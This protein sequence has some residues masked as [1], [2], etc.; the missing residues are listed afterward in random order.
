MWTKIAKKSDFKEGVGQLFEISGKQIAVFKK[1]GE[2][3]ALHNLCEHRGGPLVE[4][5]IDANDVV[6]P[7]HAWA[8]D[9][10][11]GV[12]SHNS[13]LSQQVFNLKTEHGDLYVET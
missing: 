12:C 1:S 3:F 9:L 5:A 4:G 2:F 7:W 6:C 8:F 10:R 11:T 13:R